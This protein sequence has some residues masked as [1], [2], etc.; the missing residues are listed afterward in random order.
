MFST[1]S[2]PTTAQ[3]SYR[4]LAA[5]EAAKL[6]P[7]ERQCQ[8]DTQR[9]RSQ[10]DDRRLRGIRPQAQG[11]KLDQ[12][13]LGVPP[14][15]AQD[16]F[17]DPDSRTMKRTGGGFDNCLNAQTVVGAAAHIIVAVEGV[18]TKSDAQ[19]TA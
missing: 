15:Q 14:A 17:T 6:R 11:S 12:R 16:G 7:E 4:C 8:A 5:I 19:A 1:S 10:D 3:K 9:G 2:Y 13:D 18:N